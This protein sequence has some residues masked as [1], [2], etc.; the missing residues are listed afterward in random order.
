M[1]S[2]RDHGTG[3]Q[4]LSLLVGERLLSEVGWCGATRFHPVDA[5]VSPD[6]C[7]RLGARLT[8]GGAR[9]GLLVMGDGSARRGPRAPGYV[10]KRALAFD[11]SVLAAVRASDP[12]ALLA[13]DA[14]LAGELLVAGR[15]AWQVLAGALDGADALDGGPL[16]EVLYADDPFGVQYL[17]WTWIS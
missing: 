4:P 13:V 10:D 8:E 12:R 6:D 11:A 5:A 14:A 7:A 9:V 16:G 3:G 17:V 1:K 2:G 15:A